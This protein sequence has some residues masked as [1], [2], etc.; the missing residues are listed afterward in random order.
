MYSRA[1]QDPQHPAD[2][3]KACSG[4][5]GTDEL[6]CLWQFTSRRSERLLRPCAGRFG[7]FARQ[8]YMITRLQIE[9]KILSLFPEK[10]YKAFCPM[11]NAC[12]GGNASP[13]SNKERKNLSIFP[14]F[15]IPK[16]FERLTHALEGR[17]SIQ[18]S[19]GTYLFMQNGESP[20]L[21]VQR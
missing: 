2:D 8:K 11:G 1:N 17:C 21:Q 6:Y 13:L 7:T 16:R 18:L 19:Y 14:L 3:R 15:V 9:H 12:L 4:K 10:A 5:R 20:H